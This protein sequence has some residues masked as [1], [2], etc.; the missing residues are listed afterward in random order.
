MLSIKK[1]HRA[2]FEA[3]QPARLVRRHRRLVPFRRLPLVVL[4][5]TWHDAQV[6]L[7]LRAVIFRL[8][9]QDPPVRVNRVPAEVAAERRARSQRWAVTGTR[10]R[11][12]REVASC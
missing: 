1:L 11:L 5:E 2:R 9:P 3:L 12:E 4:L 7:A 6:R 10:R 8:A